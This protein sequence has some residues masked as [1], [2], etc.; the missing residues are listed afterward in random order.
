MSI[1]RRNPNQLLA[2]MRTALE[3][4]RSQPEIARIMARRGYDQGTLA[5]G[6]ALLQKGEESI[7]S[8]Q[9]EYSEQYEA[10]GELHAHWAEAQAL[11]TEYRELVRIALKNNGA[12]RAAFG[13]GSERKYSLT[14]WM[15]EATDFYINL[16][17]DQETLDALNRR[18]KVSRDELESARN[19]VNQLAQL[20][21]Q[22]RTQMA[23]AQDATE[24]R[25][26][27]L[28]QVDDWYTDFTAVARILLSNKPDYLT[29][30]KI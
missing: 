28:D 6:F 27:I 25:D 3:S 10:T 19:G 14:G 20:R 29:A 8:Q 7:A 5:E 15:R 12:K 30:L 22:Q 23:E 16:L 13:F 4:T 24:T 9:R 17:S 18:F 26:E 21:A 1:H 11:Y 2:N